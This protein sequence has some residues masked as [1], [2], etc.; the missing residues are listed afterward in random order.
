VR[1][2]LA[3]GAPARLELLD[4]AGRRMAERELT[5]LGPGPHDVD[6]ASRR[7]LPAGIYL[8]RLSEGQA[9]AVRRVAL[10]P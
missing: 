3:G 9:V 4:V 1:L 10:L 7:R 8:V 2:S 6:L 5:A